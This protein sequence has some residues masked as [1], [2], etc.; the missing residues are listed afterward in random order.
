[1]VNKVHNHNIHLHGDL[2]R[3]H[4]FM[5]CA[6]PTQPT[7]CPDGRQHH[8]H[9]QEPCTIRLNPSARVLHAKKPL[10]V[11]T[12]ES[13]SDTGLRVA[14][15]QVSQ[16]SAHN[17]VW[18]NLGV[19]CAIFNHGTCMCPV[20]ACLRMAG[21]LTIALM[22]CTTAVAHD[23]QCRHVYMIRRC[24]PTA[25]T[26]PHISGGRHRHCI[27]HRGLYAGYPDWRLAIRCAGMQGMT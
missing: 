24:L 6:H 20:A 27:R 17:T 25:I 19:S 4:R 10:G 5:V 18:H 12:L 8:S 2:P 15:I 11:D 23:S 26:P 22:D 13:T 1:M 7:P 14:H 21:K 16:P 9:H 3:A